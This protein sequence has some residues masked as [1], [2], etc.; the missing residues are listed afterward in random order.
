[1]ARGFLMNESIAVAAFKK[2][3][4]TRREADVL[5]W[6]ARGKSNVEI[7]M[8]LCISPRT[9]KKH[10]EHVFRKLGVR[11]RLAAAVVAVEAFSA[12]SAIRSKRRA[13]KVRIRSSSDAL[14][15]PTGL[16]DFPHKVVRPK[17]TEDQPPR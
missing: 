15:L 8:A 14:K 6:I 13:R 11:T 4:L 2:L 9:V 16:Q 10:L 12:Q 5:L 7:S 1:M 3:G 17:A